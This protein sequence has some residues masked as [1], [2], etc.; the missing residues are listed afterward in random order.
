MAKIPRIPNALAFAKESEK[1]GR[2]DIQGE[3]GFSWYEDITDAKSFSKAVTALGPVSLIE[4]HINS[5]GGSVFDGI[6]M[7]N[8]LVQHDAQVHVYIDGVAASIAS[9]IAMAGDKIFMPSNTMLF[10]HDPLM[11]TVGNAEELRKDADMLDRAKEALVNSYLRHLKG[12]S[13]TVASLMKAETW[14]T[15]EEAA[16]TFNNISVLSQKK[17]VTASLDMHKLGTNI[18]KQARAF[19]YEKEEPPKSWLDRVVTCLNRRGFAKAADAVRKDLLNSTEDETQQ[20]ENDMTLEEIAALKTELVTETTTIVTHSMEALKQTLIEAKL[21]PDPAA[22]EE[23]KT[24]IPFEGD[25]SKPEDVQA[26]LTKL[27]QAKGAQILA[28]GDEKQIK[29]YLASLTPAPVAPAAPVARVQP[30]GNI[31]IADMNAGEQ[32]Q[33][34]ADAKAVVTSMTSFMPKI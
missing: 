3:I 29:T 26:H 11:Y 12:S 25:P 30:F 1:V 13:D 28:S 31:P 34:Q 18:P 32:A 8:T 20:E 27:A 7:Y 16:N 24:A 10:V 9:V 21:L 4:V 6:S 17:E 14:L 15:A 33:K 2:L 23:P 19:L 5:V 22:K